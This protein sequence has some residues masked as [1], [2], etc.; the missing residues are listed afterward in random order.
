VRAFDLTRTIVFNGR[1]YASVEEMPAEERRLYEEALRQAG[2]LFTGGGR[3]GVSVS[4]DLQT[5]ILHNGREYRDPEGL[6]AEVRLQ[7][8][9]A[10]GGARP[11]EPGDGPLAG[12]V[13]I[14]V[15]KAFAWALAIWLLLKI[16]L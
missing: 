9:R 1:E 11:I 14:T 8:E 12:R 3:G 2:P 7:Y 10:M 16:A 4:T 5:R 15:V 6:P 13:V